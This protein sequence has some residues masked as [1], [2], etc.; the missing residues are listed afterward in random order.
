[1]QVSEHNLSKL[2][3][4]TGASQTRAA[5]VF[6]ETKGKNK[7]K[8]KQLVRKVVNLEPITHKEKII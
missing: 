7:I 2:F 8:K 4:L 6:F 1:M 3:C 5:Q